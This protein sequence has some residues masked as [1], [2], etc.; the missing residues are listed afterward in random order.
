MPEEVEAA[1]K[2]SNKK[3][4]KKDNLSECWALV[5][6]WKHKRYMYNI[7]IVHIHMWTDIIELV[8]GHKM[9]DFWYTFGWHGWIV[10]L[11][12]W[13]SGRAESLYY[14]MDYSLRG[15]DATSSQVL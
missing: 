12:V 4:E 15:A 13:E 5:D 7:Y 8:W 1:S 6:V 14:N 11:I 3:K 9:D 10:T 2:S